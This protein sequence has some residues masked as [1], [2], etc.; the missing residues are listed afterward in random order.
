MILTKD[1]QGA[2]WLYF[3]H[4]S[5]RA[6]VWLGSNNARTFDFTEGDT[7]IFPDNSGHY[8]ENLSYTETLTYLEVFHS[9]VVED[10]SLQQWLAL[11]PPDLVAQV[12][13]VSVPFLEKLKTEK[14]VLV[15]A[16]SA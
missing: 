9:N 16:Q 10:V 2:E 13:N 7:A 4:G 12:L 6:T 1:L 3:Q 5:A 14:Q 15:A 11:T 8:V